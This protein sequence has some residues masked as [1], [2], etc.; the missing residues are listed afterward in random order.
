MDRAK[1]AS[2]ACFVRWQSTDAWHCDWQYFPKL[3]FWRDIFP[4]DL[5][6]RLPQAAPGEQLEVPVE[7]AALPATGGTAVREL[8]RHQL[9]QVFSAR[10]FPGPY[11]GRFYPR[12][13]LADCAGF[14]DLFKDDYHPF[15]VAALDGQRA[16][17]D[18]SHPLA[19]FSLTF[20]A[21][22]ER[23]L[24]GGE[25]H[26]GQCS[27]LLAEITDKGPGMQCRPSHGVAD[28]FRDGAFERLDDTPDDRF[29]RSPRLVQHIDTAGQALINRIYR[30]FIRPD[31]RVLDLMSSWVSHL[32]GIPAPAQVD[33][34]GINREEMAQ[35]PRLASARVADLNLDPRLPFDDNSYDVVVCSL[36]VEYLIHPLQVFAE[37]ARVLRPGGHFILTFSDR[38]FPPKAIASWSEMHPFERLGLVLEYFRASGR[39]GNLGSESYCGWPRPEDDKYYPQKQY[40]DPVFAAWGQGL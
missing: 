21:E 17:V 19:D 22:I 1:L 11:V 39:F 10:A 33:G 8:L 36:S 32:Q 18:L 4:G 13:L 40:A 20:G 23:L 27:D 29:Y 6:E 28:F 31:H 34:L 16:R 37:V 14:G 26:G 12:G 35:N 9:D 24:E 2:A 38:W 7:R 25:E 5:A 15:R 3:N 30:R